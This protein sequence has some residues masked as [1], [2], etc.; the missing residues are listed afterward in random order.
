MRR[1]DWR[2]DGVKRCGILTR[3]LKSGSEVRVDGEDDMV[4]GSVDVVVDAGDREVARTVAAKSSSSSAR[5]VPPVRMRNH[6]CRQSTRKKANSPSSS[7]FSS[8]THS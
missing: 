2:L 6:N 3:D 5:A 8:Y 4:L 7:Y 1:A